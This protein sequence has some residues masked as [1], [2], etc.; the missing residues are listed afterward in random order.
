M[1]GIFHTV[2]LPVNPGA[3]RNLAWPA[4]DP[5]TARTLILDC[6]AWV[7]DAGTAIASVQVQRDPSLLVSGITTDGSVVRLKVSGG[8]AGTGTVIGFTLTL[9]D[10]DVEDVTVLLPIAPLSPA[11]ALGAIT[12][13]DTG[14]AALLL[15]GQILTLGGMPLTLGAA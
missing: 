6:A 3:I 1:A 13:G 11:P 7:A 9:A 14:A 8:V 4:Q 12:M 10:G 2:T 5:G 15:G